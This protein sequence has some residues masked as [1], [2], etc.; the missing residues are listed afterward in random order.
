MRKL[1]NSHVNDNMPLNHRTLSPN[2][3]TSSS[4]SSSSL[5]SYSDNSDDYGTDTELIEIDKNRHRNLLNRYAI[6]ILLE[7]MYLEGN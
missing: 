7:V 1:D 2:S 6:N 3:M 4:S 5:S